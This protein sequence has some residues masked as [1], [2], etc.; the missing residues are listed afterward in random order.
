MHAGEQAG[1]ASRYCSEGPALRKALCL[2]EGHYH[3]EILNTFCTR[4][5]SGFHEH[6]LDSPLASPP[7]S[8][9]P[10]QG[11]VTPRRGTFWRTLLILHDPA[12]MA[13]KSTRAPPGSPEG[14]SSAFL[15]R[16]SL[17]Q[18][19]PLSVTRPRLPTSRPR[20]LY[21][22]FLKTERC[23]IHLLTEES[24]QSYLLRTGHR[25]QHTVGAQSVLLTHALSRLGH[26]TTWPCPPSTRASHRSDRHSLPF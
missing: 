9:F 22:D 25:A 26:R 14:W 19:P 15:L 10:R 21:S 1:L 24:K 13:F 4:D 5:P 16:S 12:E 7:G 23:S 2:A 8:C 3:L 17:P 6:H 11:S 18:R 20:P